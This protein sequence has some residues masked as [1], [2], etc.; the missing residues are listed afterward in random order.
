MLPDHLQLRYPPEPNTSRMSSVENPMGKFF[1][2][3]IYEIPMSACSRIVKKNEQV[4]QNVHNSRIL[5][6]F[7]VIDELLEST[8]DFK[9]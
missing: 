6:K 1:R 8:K 5:N 9:S 3:E 4:A 2:D 7:T